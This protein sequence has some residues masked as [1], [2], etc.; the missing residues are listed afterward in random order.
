MK[1]AWIFAIFA[2]WSILLAEDSTGIAIIEV[3]NVPYGKGIVLVQKIG[4]PPSFGLPEARLSEESPIESSLRHRM[5][6]MLGLDVLDFCVIEYRCNSHLV[7]PVCLGHA[8]G[9]PIADP[10][11][12]QSAWAAPFDEIP[13]E[14]LPEDHR[15]ILEQY[16]RMGSR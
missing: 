9:A 7:Q 8:H 16:L 3:E 1:C 11:L 15:D 14:C 5:K 12:L 10:E 6:E 2:S 4:D 13:W